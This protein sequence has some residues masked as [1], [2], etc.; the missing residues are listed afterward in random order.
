MTDNKLVIPEYKI[1]LLNKTKKIINVVEN[2]NKIVETNA[3]Y[4]SSKDKKDKKELKKQP[5]DKVINLKKTKKD[6]SKKEN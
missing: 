1:E 6:S 3:D 5:S 4:K 2:I